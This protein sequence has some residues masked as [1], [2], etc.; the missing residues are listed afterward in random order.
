MPDALPV[1]ARLSPS[2]RHVA[3]SLER[4]HPLIPQ[5]IERPAPVERS[6]GL[7]RTS[8]VNQPPSQVQAVSRGLH[9]RSPTAPEPQNA[10]NG[11]LIGAAPTAGNAKGKTWAVGADI[12]GDVDRDLGGLGPY[13][14]EPVRERESGKEARPPL[15]SAPI[16]IT[17][18]KAFQVCKHL[19]YEFKS[20]C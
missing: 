12:V 2:A 13:G 17:G 19:Y 20:F 7:Q 8:S 16:Q 10:S 9:R 11:N 6:Q 3:V 5:P 1:P 15:P 18:A 14:D 4:N